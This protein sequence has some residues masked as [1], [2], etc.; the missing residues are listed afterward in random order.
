MV[1]KVCRSSLD[2]DLSLEEMCAEFLEMYGPDSLTVS[3]ATTN[4]IDDDRTVDELYAEFMGTAAG[5]N[6]LQTEDRTTCLT[7]IVAEGTMAEDNSTPPPKPLPFLHVRAIKPS[8][9]VVTLR[10]PDAVMVHSIRTQFDPGG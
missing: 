4:C 3:M 1:P 10:S 8:S 2:A 7:I 9:I 5:A 6:N